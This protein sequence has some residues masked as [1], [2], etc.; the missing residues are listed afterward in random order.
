[1][2]ETIIKSDIG[3]TIEGK[4]LDYAASIIVGRSLPGIKDGLKPSH[5]RILFSMYQN[6]LRY[7]KPHRKAARVIGDIIGLYHPH[8][9]EA[10]Y[11]AQVRLGQDFVHIHPLIDAQGNVGSIDDKNSFAAMRYLEVRLSELAEEFIADLPYNC[12]DM[13][14]NYDS[15]EMEPV[16]LPVSFPYFLLAGQSG[17]AVGFATSCL[18]LNLGELSTQ[19]K[20]KKTLQ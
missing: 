19:Q 8:A 4:Y 13:V 3:P 15:S 16:E 1:L 5:R 14:P 6:N 2:S 11:E 7:N 10:L 12:V 18:P 17:I 9:P 20:G